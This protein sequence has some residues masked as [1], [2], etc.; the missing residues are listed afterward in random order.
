MTEDANVNAD[1]SQGNTDGGDSKGAQDQGNQGGDKSFIESLPEG[2]RGFE[3]FKDIQDVGTLATRYVD[4]VKGLPVIPEK[5]EAY[6]ITVPDGLPVDEN[7]LTGF[8]GVAHQAKLTQE[9]VKTVTD[10]WNGTLQA[11]I[12]QQ[13]KV[14]EE[15]VKALKDEWKGDFDKNLELSKTALKKMGGEELAAYLEES[16]L[17]DNPVMIKFFHKLGQTISEDSFVEGKRKPQ[18]VKRTPGGTPVLRFPSME[19]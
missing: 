2:I 12:A 18:E 8:K 10:W 1:T 4:T 15:T 9:Q 3:G 16:K 7:F 5:P 14:Q 6:E 13:A 19:K 17:G 11:G